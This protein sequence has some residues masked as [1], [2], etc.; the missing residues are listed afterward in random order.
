MLRG[1]CRQLGD[2]SRV[3]ASAQAKPSSPGRGIDSPLTALLSRPVLAV[4][5]LLSLGLIAARSAFERVRLFLATPA[6][7]GQ[8]ADAGTRAGGRRVRD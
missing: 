1:L 7:C 4:V 2:M 6:A 8:P 5:I 3:L